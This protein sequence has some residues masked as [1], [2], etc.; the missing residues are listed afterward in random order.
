MDLGNRGNASIV[1]GPIVP[2]DSV[3]ENRWLPDERSGWMPLMNNKPG[4]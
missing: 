3:V 2:Y 1:E 4:G